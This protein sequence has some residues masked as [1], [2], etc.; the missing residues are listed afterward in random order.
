MM[1]LLCPAKCGVRRFSRFNFRPHP[2][3]HSHSSG[4]TLVEILVAVTLLSMIMLAMNG[5]LRTIGQTESRVDQR[6]TR[7]DD[8]R[9]TVQLLQQTLGRI[10]GHVDQPQQVGQGAAAV[11]FRANADSIEWVGIMPARPGVG[12][13]HFFRL[14]LETVADSSRQLVLRFAPWSPD[15]AAPDWGAAASRIMG[16]RITQFAVQA[17]GVPPRGLMG[18]PANWPQGWVDGWPPTD[19]LPDRIR[20]TLADAQGEWP[21]IVI[22]VHNLQQGAGAG[23]LFSIGGGR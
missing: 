17:Q 1:R 10:S 2:R 5:A 3:P 9:W 7:T 23:S 14:Q 22:P 20:L 19:A 8:M 4:F 21:E 16:G 18:A 13:R 6:L 15:A 11:R 12:G